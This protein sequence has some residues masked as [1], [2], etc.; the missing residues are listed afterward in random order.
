[1]YYC[2]SCSEYFKVREADLRINP[3]AALCPHCGG[4]DTE[5]SPEEEIQ[6]DD[7]PDYNRYSEFDENDYLKFNSNEDDF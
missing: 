2:Y 3:N 6:D 5:Y 7:Y 1:M 4:D